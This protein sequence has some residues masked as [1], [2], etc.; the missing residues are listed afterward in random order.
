MP[1]IIPAK[2]EIVKRQTSNV[3]ALPDDLRFL[4]FFANITWYNSILSAGIILVCGES[5]E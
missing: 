1:S 5:Y 3:M 2:A 4:P